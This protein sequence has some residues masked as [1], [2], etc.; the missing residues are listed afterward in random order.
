MAGELSEGYGS[1]LSA[2]AQGADE[3]IPGVAGD[4]PCDRGPR[5]KTYHLSEHSLAD[6]HAT[7]VAQRFTSAHDRDLSRKTRA[8]CSGSSDRRHSNSLLTQ[9]KTDTYTR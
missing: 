1:I 8:R 7:K 3:A 5:E 4:D 2:I 9:W 6:V